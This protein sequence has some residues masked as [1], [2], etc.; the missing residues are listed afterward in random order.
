MVDKK[1]GG[2][3]R[4]MYNSRKTIIKRIDSHKLSSDLYM[5][6]MACIYTINVKNKTHTPQKDTYH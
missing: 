2:E 1:K 3:W 4:K 6:T 5:C